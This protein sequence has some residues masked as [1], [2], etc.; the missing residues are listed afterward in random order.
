M[1]GTGV[2]DGTVNDQSGVP[3]GGTGGRP[4]FRDGDRPDPGGV[5][6]DGPALD[7]TAPDGTGPGD[8]SPDTGD[9]GG[10]A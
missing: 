9:D 1:A 2:A 6:P 10:T 8:T 4:D 7:G 5:R 3:N